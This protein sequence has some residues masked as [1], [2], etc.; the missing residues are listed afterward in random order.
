MTPKEL[1]SAGR[2]REAISGLAN[3]LRSHPDDI[4]Q[5]TFLFEL[6]CFAGQYDRAEKQLGVL[7]QGGPEA[8]LGAILYMSALHG[9]RTRHEL[10]AK[11]AYPRQSAAPSPSGTLNGK[12]FT[13]IRDADPAIGAR[14]E[15]LAAGAYLWIPFEHV[16]AVEMGPPKRLRDTLWAPATVRT[17]PSFKGQELGEVLIPVIYPF[18]WNNPDEE[19]WLGRKTEWVRD[20]QGNEYPVG[21]KMLVIDGEEVPFLELRTLQFA[22]AEVAAG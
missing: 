20:D 18:S 12:A 10:F 13:S 3:Y 22:P 1:F 21:Q 6:L 9:E 19:V 8:E 15:V 14:L 4:P 16:A 5:R 17:G 2:V 11:Q 7:S